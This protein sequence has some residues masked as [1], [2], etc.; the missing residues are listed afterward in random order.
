MDHKSQHES[1]QAEQWPRVV[2][3]GSG[4]LLDRI[5]AGLARPQS[6]HV[7]YSL[8]EEEPRELDDLAVTVAELEVGAQPTSDQRERVKIA[9]YHNVLPKLA[10]LQLVE[11]DPRSRMVCFREPPP[12]LDEFIRLCRRFDAV[13]V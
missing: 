13:A 5:L 10:D 8:A 6:R 3:D 7:L 2:A 9:I 1:L 4:T 12:E 11:Y